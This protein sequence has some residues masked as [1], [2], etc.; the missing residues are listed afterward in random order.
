MASAIRSNLGG[1]RDI[2]ITT[3]GGG[4]VDVSLLDGYFT[5]G[6]LDVLA[7]HAYGTGDYV[8]SKLAGYV[9]KAQ[10]HGKKLL[11]QEWGACYYSNENERCGPSSV[12][13]LDAT[14]RASNIW[15]WSGQISKAGIPWMYWQVLPNADPHEDWDYEVGVQENIWNTLA[16]AMNA[17]RSY[18]SAFDYSHY[19][20]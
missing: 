17:T 13:V 1:N 8:T 3:G 4:W 7:I 2:L 12:G 16:G 6:D 5:C 18:S 10:S 14:T 15:Q 19:L 20:L 11:M 9:F